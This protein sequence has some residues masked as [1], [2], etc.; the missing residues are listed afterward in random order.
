MGHFIDEPQNYR[1]TSE[2]K[3]PKKKQTLPGPFL[4]SVFN[5]YRHIFFY[6]ELITKNPFFIS[7]H[8]YI[9]EYKVSYIFM[10]M[11]SFKYFNNFYKK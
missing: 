5:L 10:I 9:I 11:M 2:K 3:C 6:E 4:T 8:T 1:V 7:Q